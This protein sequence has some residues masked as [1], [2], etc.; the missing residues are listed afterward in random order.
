MIA[1]NFFYIEYVESTPCRILMTPVSVVYYINSFSRYIIGS[2]VASILLRFELDGCA[3]DYGWRELYEVM[4][5]TF[6]E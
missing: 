3:I 5:S 4:L 6:Q 2:S 1:A